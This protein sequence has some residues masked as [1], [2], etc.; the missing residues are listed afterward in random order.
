MAW[1]GKI[2]H[3]S[4]LR[5][6]EID[7]LKPHPIKFLDIGC[8]LCDF[9]AKAWNVN[10]ANKVWAMDVS[11]IVVERAGKKFPIFELVSMQR[12]RFRTMSSLT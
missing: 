9:T 8:A 5:I 10:R 6:I 7:L 4:Y 12:Q 1:H 11:Q 2:R 3:Q